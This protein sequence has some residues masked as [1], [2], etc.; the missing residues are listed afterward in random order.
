MTSRK[1][2]KVRVVQSLPCLYDGYP[3]SDPCPQSERRTCTIKHPARCPAAAA[4]RA[5]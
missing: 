2:P 4:R 3:E 1:K 5:R